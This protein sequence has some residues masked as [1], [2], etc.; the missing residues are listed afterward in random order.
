MRVRMLLGALFAMV[1]I[2]LGLCLMF[3]PG[4]WHELLHGA[5][6]RTTFFFMQAAGVA[7]VTRA[8]FCLVRVRRGGWGGLYA[9]TVAAAL[10]LAWVTADTSAWAAPVYIG[11]ALFWG[12]GAWVGNRYAHR[13]SGDEADSIGVDFT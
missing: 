13:P 7:L 12:I 10:Y 3:W 6:E 5:L 2:C 11:L 8:L 4:A 1:D 9:L